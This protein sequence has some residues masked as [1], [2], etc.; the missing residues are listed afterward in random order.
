[1]G[2]LTCPCLNISV[3]VKSNTLKPLDSSKLR[4]TDEQ[5]EVKFFAH[6]IA[7]VQLDLGGISEV[8]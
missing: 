1:M 7:D 3:H 5:R 4:L 8:S 2:K 6:D